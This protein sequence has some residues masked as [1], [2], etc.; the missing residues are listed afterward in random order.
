M[1][2]DMKA[3]FSIKPD[4]KIFAK[5]QTMVFSQYIFVWEKK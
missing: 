5:C 2:V 4:R 3:L 1:E